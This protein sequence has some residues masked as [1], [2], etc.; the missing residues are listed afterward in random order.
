MKLPK[1]YYMIFFLYGDYMDE[2]DAVSDFGFKGEFNTRAQAYK[3]MQKILKG[4]LPSEDITGCHSVFMAGIDPDDDPTWAEYYETMTPFAPYEVVDVL[5]KKEA[6]EEAVDPINVAGD[7]DISNDKFRH[8]AKEVAMDR[9]M[10][11]GDDGEA[12]RHRKKLADP[13][14]RL[15]PLRPVNKKK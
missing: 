15:S 14:D 5:S 13:A 1:D 3:A 10:V 7:L 2:G 9:E 8:V 12:E 6:L 11:N 4:D